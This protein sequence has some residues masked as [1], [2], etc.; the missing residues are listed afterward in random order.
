MFCLLNLDYKIMGSQE[1]SSYS[2]SCWGHGVSR[3]KDVGGGEGII[4]KGQTGWW[5]VR[6]E[7]NYWPRVSAWCRICCKPCLLTFKSFKVKQNTYY[8]VSSAC[9]SVPGDL[10]KTQKYKRSVHFISSLWEMEASIV[11]KLEG[12][13]S[14]GD[15]NKHGDNTL[16]QRHWWGPSSC[17]SWGEPSSS[18]TVVGGSLPVLPGGSPLLVLPGGALFLSFL[19]GNPLPVLPVTGSHTKLAEP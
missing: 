4:E 15:E 11:K 9:H 17:P 8:I 16:P 13:W 14:R 19:G 6:V 12:K 5:K 7:E 18:K 10:G 3:E 1:A 2:K